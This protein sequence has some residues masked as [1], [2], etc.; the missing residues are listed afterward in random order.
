MKLTL[1]KCNIVFDDLILTFLFVAIIGFMPTSHSGDSMVWFVA[2]GLFAANTIIKRKEIK[3]SISFLW[4]IMLIA[5]GSIS[6]LWS[7][8]TTRYEIYM[9]FTFLVICVIVIFISGYIDDEK[10][11]DHLMYIIVIASCFAG[12]RYC[13]Y[14]DWQSIF[15]SRYYM[16]GTF[17]GLLDDVTN[18][19]NYTAP[20]SIGCIIASY[21]TFYKNQKLSIIPFLLLTAILVFSGSR[22]VII[23][24][25]IVAVFFSLMKGNVK[26]KAISILS[27]I[28]IIA[29]TV[30]I[31]NHVDFMSQIRDKINTL[32]NS[33]FDASTE[34]DNS[35]YLRSQMRNAGLN[36][37]LEHIFFGVGWDNFRNYNPV[38]EVTAHN[39]FIE[40]LA[41][42]GV[43]GLI[44]YYS[45]Y[46]KIGYHC[47][48]KIILKVNNSYDVFIL[49]LIISQIIKEYGSVTIYARG[50]MPL[51]LI[52]ILSADVMNHKVIQLKI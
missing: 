38:S 41:S 22:K 43:F 6:C 28:G 51:I 3:F 1:K 20:L 50:T 40:I 18:Y 33:F 39:N 12:L 31:L 23:V 15:S 16:R 21:Y 4:Y 42:L 44:L 48:R 37:W 46:V 29:V 47:I 10:S 45:L 2:V 27:I 17:G 32:I 7:L 26:K 13:Y 19:N 34:L 9:K 35:S 8:N 36:V 24:I 49:G 11:V 30:Y 14:T 52:L 25:P 5:Y